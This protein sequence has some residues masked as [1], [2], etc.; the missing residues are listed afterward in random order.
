MDIAPLICRLFRAHL[1]TIKPAEAKTPF[2]NCLLYIDPSPAQ[3]SASKRGGHPRSDAAPTARFY[4]GHP[5]DLQPRQVMDTI[6]DRLEE[7]S[8][9]VLRGI[10][11]KA[12]PAI[13]RN[14]ISTT[15]GRAFFFLD[16]PLEGKFSTEQTLCEDLRGS[17]AY[18][19]T[20]IGIDLAKGP[21]AAPR[22]VRRSQ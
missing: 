20:G 15:T 1:N 2:A 14:C 16:L 10:V 7:V 13:P 19:A 21:P 6:L 5:S 3:S 18:R 22:S 9:P 8:A 17:V 4:V 12:K 11:S